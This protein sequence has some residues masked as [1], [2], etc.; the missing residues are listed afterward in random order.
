M[1]QLDFD[2]STAR[3][4]L[5]QDPVAVGYSSHEG[6]ERAHWGDDKL[7]TRRRQPSRRLSGRRLA[8][9]QVHGGAV[10]R[11]LGQGRRRLRRHAQS[12]RRDSPDREDHPERRSSR[13]ARVPVDRLPGT[14]GGAPAGV[15]QRADRPQSEDA[16]DEADH[17]VGELAFEELRRAHGR[18]VRDA[19][20]RLLLRRRRDRLERV[21]SSSF[22]TQDRR[23]SCWPH[24]S[25]SGCSPS[26]ARR[27]GRRPRSGSL[28]GAIG[29]RS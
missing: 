15:L 1:I 12:A 21:S 8:R 10:P 23:S 25:H 11:Q 22:A 17:L 4:A 14:L 29:A 27:G 24:S 5:S 9:E 3:D 26:R 6:A 20:D 16:M 18:R 28:D 13:A 19:R 2:A 7:E